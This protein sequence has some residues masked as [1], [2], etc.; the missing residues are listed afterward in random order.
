MIFKEFWVFLQNFYVKGINK[1]IESENRATVLSTVNMFGSLIS[2]IL[3]PFIGLLV[4]WNIY[5]VFFIIG[6]LIII[7][8]GF[9]RVKNEYL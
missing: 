2:A 3:Y 8:T 5:V 7:F 6:I 1:Q 9:T 4:M